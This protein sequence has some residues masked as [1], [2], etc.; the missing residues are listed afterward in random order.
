MIQTDFRCHRYEPNQQC[1]Q[2]R[3]YSL[4]IITQLAANNTTVKTLFG[5]M[6]PFMSMLA[7]TLHQTH[8]ALNDHLHL[9]TAVGN[10]LHNLSWKTDYASKQMMRDVKMVAYLIEVRFVLNQSMVLIVLFYYYYLFIYL[11]CHVDKGYYDM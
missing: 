4:N 9:I 10:V 8:S 1:Y 6:R 5:P 3:I 11:D 7:E 2:L